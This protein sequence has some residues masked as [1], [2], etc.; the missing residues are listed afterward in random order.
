MMSLLGE[1][2]IVGPAP[3]YRRKSRNSG[4][5]LSQRVRDACMGNKVQKKKEEAQDR[6]V[7]CTAFMFRVGL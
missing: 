7:I 4:I 5:R 6:N 2:K 1:K 3:I